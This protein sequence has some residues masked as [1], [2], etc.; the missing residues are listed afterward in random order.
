[1][2]FAMKQGDS[3]VPPEPSPNCGAHMVVLV[4][5]IHELCK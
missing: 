3:V 4:S 2:S 1:M 5:R